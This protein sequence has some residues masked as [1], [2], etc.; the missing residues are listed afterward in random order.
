VLSHS[1]ADAIFWIAAVCCGLAQAAV[2]RSSMVAPMLV[3]AHAGVARPRRAVES[4]WAILPAI[5]LAILLI[6]T[7]VAM[8]D[9]WTVVV[10]PLEVQPAGGRQ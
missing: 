1:I 6:A 8:H 7:W 10:P 2:I 4:M 5:A 3:P 9:Y